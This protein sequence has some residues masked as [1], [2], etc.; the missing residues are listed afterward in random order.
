MKIAYF[1]HDVN[2][3]AVARRVAMLQASGGEPVLIGFRRRDDI[4]EQVGGAPVVDLGKT[5]DAQ[6]SQ[7]AL[8]VLWALVAPGKILAASAGA[9]VVIGRNLESLALAARVRRAAPKAALVYECL[10]IHRL[11]LGNSMPARA[12]Q[13][14]EAALLRQ[15]DLLLTSSPAFEREYFRNRPTLHAPI[16]LLENKLLKIDQPPPTAPPAPDGPPWSIGW[17]GMLRCARTFDALAGL[18]RRGAGRVRVEIAGRPSPA[19][20]PDFA[21]KVAAVPGMIFHGAYR[22][23]DLAALYGRCHFAWAID[24]F[25]E[26]LN[27]KWLLPNRI[28]EAASFGVVPIA[29]REVET[30]RWLAK[31]GAGVQLDRGPDE[32]DAFFGALEPP[33]Y[34]ALRDAVAAIPKIDLIAD[35]TDCDALMSSL[36]MAR[37]GRI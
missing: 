13:A 1:V 7:R 32:L 26:G 10:D 24:Y 33:R 16:L 11:L 9:E 35:R 23:E 2:D 22:P 6:M 20:F 5:R 3:A 18:V 30:G 14:I 8:A 12:I 17:F 36:S 37:A 29:L 4:T 19:V 31:Y 15:V 21:A 34:A 25:E 28:Y 27:S